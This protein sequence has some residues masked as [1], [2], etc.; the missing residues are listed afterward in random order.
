MHIFYKCPLTKQR[1]DLG[2]AT[3]CANLAKNWHHMQ[4]RKCPH[5]SGVHTIDVTEAYLDSILDESMLRGEFL[6]VRSSAAT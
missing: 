2:V 3:D 1:F 4:R 6:K 5:C